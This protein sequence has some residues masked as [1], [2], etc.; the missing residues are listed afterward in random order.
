MEPDD[1]VT[2]G[3][4]AELLGVPANRVRV[5]IWRYQIEP[6]GRVGRWNVYDYREIAAIEARSRLAKI[7]A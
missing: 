1:L 2:P 7:A 4:A 5:W 6:L 3:Q